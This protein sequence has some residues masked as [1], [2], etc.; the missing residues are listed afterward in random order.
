[1]SKSF[2]PRQS[3]IMCALSDQ[4]KSGAPFHSGY[5]L[6]SRLGDDGRSRS[7]TR[8][9]DSFDLRHD[10]S[11][12][13][14]KLHLEGGE[15]K[16]LRGADETLRRC[17]PIVV[18]SVDHNDDGLW[19]TQAFLMSHLEDYGFLFRNHAWQASCSMIYAIPK[20]RAAHAH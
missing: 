12:T 8:K 1:D 9:I 3:T 5:G 4:D 15:L 20:E 19:R 6:M 2:D 14:I 7:M 13:F 18:A 16:A 11:P 17:R 10:R